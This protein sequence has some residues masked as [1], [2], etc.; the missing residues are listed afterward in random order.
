MHIKLPS[1][2]TQ[3]AGGAWGPPTGMMPANQRLALE[4]RVPCA[5][6]MQQPQQPKQALQLSKQGELAGTARGNGSAAGSSGTSGLHGTWTRWSSYLRFRQPQASGTPP[7]RGP[8][9]QSGQPSRS[10]AAASKA[11]RP[12]NGLTGQDSSQAVNGKVA[13]RGVGVKGENGTHALCAGGDAD[14]P[15]VIDLTL[16]D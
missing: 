11:H 8:A 6:G 1:A 10:R 9:K 13:G 7:A 3:R 16:D 5:S 4:T 2:A 15:D 12:A 14:G